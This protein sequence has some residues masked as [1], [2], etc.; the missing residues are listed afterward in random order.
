MQEPK[1]VRISIFGE[2]YMIKGLSSPEVVQKVASLV[3]EMMKEIAGKHPALDH[4]KLAV[5]AAL[6]IAYQLHVREA[7]NSERQ[8]AYDRQVQAL[9]ALNDRLMKLEKDEVEREA[10]VQS[11]NNQLNQLA[12]ERSRLKEEKEHLQENVAALK[13]ELER[14]KA[15]Y[16]GAQ[17]EIRELYGLL[18]ETTT[19]SS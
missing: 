14:L 16:Q 9:E 19:Q 13:S 10:L 12:E 11:L 15:A 2:H 5:L 4:H 8:K 7:E 6:N 17:E 3:D 1:S 18:D